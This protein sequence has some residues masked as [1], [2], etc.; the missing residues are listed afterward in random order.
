MGTLP[1]KA[2]LKLKIWTTKPIKN[3]A[4]SIRL[5]DTKEETRFSALNLEILVW[6]ASWLEELL[7]AERLP[8]R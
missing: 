3:A 4:T 5:N 1:T 7:P 8:T 2:A 6:N